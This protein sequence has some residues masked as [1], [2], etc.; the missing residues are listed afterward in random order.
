MIT[1]NGLL[2]DLVERQGSDLHLRADSPPVFRI[3]GD[4]VRA[5][6]TDLSPS[7]TAALISSM[8]TSQQLN[9]LQSEKE[10]DISYE[11]PAVG[12]FRVN[13][14]RERNW[15]SAALRYVPE[16]VKTIN[17]LGLPK[18]LKQIALLPRGLVIVTGP[19]GCGKSTTLAAMIEH[20]N[21]H[22]SVHIVT[23]EDPIEFS[24]VSRKA[25]ISQREIGSDTLSFGQAL[26]HVVRQSPD[27]IMVGEMRDPETIQTS[28]TAAELGHLVISTLHTADTAQAV[29]R[30]VDCFEPERQAQIRTQLSLTLQ[31]IIYQTLARRCDVKGR[32][33]AFEILIFTPAARNL[34]REGKTEQLHGLVETGGEYGMQLLDAHL[35]DLCMQGIITFDEAVLK[36]LSPK[37]FQ[38]RSM[39]VVGVRPEIIG[40]GTSHRRG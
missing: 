35:L 4:L 34:V 24:F 9:R 23:I 15:V 12:R 25:S 32:V 36:S 13:I 38:A 19:T 8:L 3:H 16:R 17:E 1:L 40:D 37:D 5:G 7:Q 20:I 27:V 18:V 31:A 14:Y 39:G 29:D 11:V 30:M 28:I 21:E 22:R 10:M 26:R 6:S 2:S 33:A